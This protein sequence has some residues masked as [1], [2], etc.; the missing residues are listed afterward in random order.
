MGDVWQ[1]YNATGAVVR[2]GVVG[3]GDVVVDVK[4]LPTGMYVVKSG[5][6]A[7]VLQVH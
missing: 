3:S 2:A 7:A 4:G 6:A 5:R 1:L